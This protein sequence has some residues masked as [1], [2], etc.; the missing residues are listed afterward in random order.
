MDIDYNNYVQEIKNVQNI[1]VT[2]IAKINPI[3][4]KNDETNKKI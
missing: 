4:V 3:G 1:N 2:T